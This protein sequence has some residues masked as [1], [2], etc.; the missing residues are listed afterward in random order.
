MMMN[1]ENKASRIRNTNTREK[2]NQNEDKHIH[3]AKGR[4]GLHPNM[5][6]ESVLC[7]QNQNICSHAKRYRKMFQFEFKMHCIEVQ[8]PFYQIGR[9][10]V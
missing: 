4:Y 6:E 3:H 9:A 7:N 8:I 2:K 5:I 10:H 1:E